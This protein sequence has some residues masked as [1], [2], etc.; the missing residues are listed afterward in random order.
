[1]AFELHSE[2]QTGT[3][4]YS[5]VEASS[6]SKRTLILPLITVIFHGVIFQLVL[7]N[8]KSNIGTYW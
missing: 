2:R 4:F 7:C 8:N 5:S 3:K 6:V 1:V